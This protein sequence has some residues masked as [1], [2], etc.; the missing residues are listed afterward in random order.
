[1]PIVTE[2]QS[3]ANPT[4]GQMPS[5]AS[6]RSIEEERQGQDHGASVVETGT[7][8][9]G[10]GEVMARVPM[11]AAERAL[12][13]QLMAQCDVLRRQI[14]YATDPPCDLLVGCLEIARGL[15]GL[16]QTATPAEGNEISAVLRRLLSRNGIDPTLPGGAHS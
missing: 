1:M 3:L 8:A 6:Q 2:N 15:Y 7:R 10:A 5:D 12:R 4:L 16:K 13:K 14:G 11:S 9:P